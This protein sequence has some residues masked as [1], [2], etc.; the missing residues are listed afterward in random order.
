MTFAIYDAYSYETA[1]WCSAA[2]LTWLCL[3]GLRKS[4]VK[5]RCEFPYFTHSFHPFFSLSSPVPLWLSLSSAAQNTDSVLTNTILNTQPH[6]HIQK[7]VTKRKGICLLCKISRS[8]F[9]SGLGRQ[10]CIGY[11]TTKF[12]FKRPQNLTGKKFSLDKSQ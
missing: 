1:S 9:N 2:C 10:D 7:A 12:P 5:T 3:C 4:G 11:Y 8:K 6:T